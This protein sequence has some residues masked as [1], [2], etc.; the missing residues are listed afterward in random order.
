MID[1]AVVI[2]Y[3][4]LV[5]L[6]GIS[7]RSKAKSLGGYGSMSGKVDT[8]KFLLVAT[9]FAT[10]VGGGTTFGIAEKAFSQDL[11]Y[12]YALMLTV[13]VDIAIAYIIVPKI[14]LHNGAV[15][16]GD[17]IGKY[18]GNVGRIITGIAAVMISVGYLAAQI[19]VSGRIFEY[20]L[21]VERASAVVLSYI[22]VIIYTTIGGLRSVVF[23]NLL[24][25]LAM[26]AAIPIVAFVG[27]NTVG[28]EK[29]VSI[30]PESKYMLDN[31]GI[32]KSTLSIALGFSVMGVIPTFIQRTLIN[33]DAKSI[34]SA[35]MI[36][37][38]IYIF[39]ITCVTLNGLLAYVMMPEADSSLAM[40]YMID[41]I[42][43]VGLKGFV[44][45]GLLAAVMSTADSDLNVASIS[46]TGDIF[47]PIFAMKDEG[48]LLNLARVVTVL[49]GSSAIA[50]ALW[51]NNVV[52]LVIFAAGF[53]APMVMVPFIAAL[54]GIV[55]S[56]RAF[57]MVSMSGIVSFLAWEMW[58]YDSELKGVFVGT[59][60][61][62]VWF[63]VERW[64]AD[65]HRR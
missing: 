15:S 7:Y 59:M 38:V 1:Q 4:A 61:S 2:G 58:M 47:R 62:L 64:R 53:W 5:L 3:L 8:S 25:F 31:W 55:V 49:I 16:V 20:I 52:D 6:V 27:L 33:K 24:Q 11:S 26:V 19:N 56:K 48:R 32:V 42:I 12:S 57:V 44:I 50:L 23:T 63:L 37:I 60:V 46:M 34:Q 54:F 10:A 28:L 36:K 40:P 39:F 22:I 18:Y 13:L 21:D 41:A 65:A 29:F 17:I 14:V 43:P 45:V 35:I 9:V 30:V 51:F